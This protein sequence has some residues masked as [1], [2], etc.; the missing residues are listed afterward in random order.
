[1][2]K[3]TFWLLLAA[4]CV[5]TAIPGC[6]ADLPGTPTP[7]SDT[8]ADAESVSATTSRLALDTFPVGIA[9]DGSN[10]E[11]YVL[12]SNELVVLDP[13]AKTV[14]N[15]APVQPGATEIAFDPAHHAAWV[16]NNR[17]SNDPADRKVNI[18]D[19][20]SKQ[21]VGSVE[22]Q[23]PALA[24]GVDSGANYAFVVNRPDDQTVSPE[25]RAWLSVFDTNTMELVSTVELP[26]AAYAIE[27]DS[28]T[29][30]AVVSGWM[31]A[32]LV[33]TQT[34][35]IDRSRNI[36]SDSSSVTAAVDSRRGAAFIVSGEKLTSIDFRT[37]SNVTEREIRWEEGPMAIGPAGRLLVTDNHNGA[38]LVI[39]PATAEVRA[40]ISVGAAPDGVAST[41]D[42][43]TAYVYSNSRQSVTVVK[44]A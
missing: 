17:R 25:A 44:F 33:S 12:A 21:M 19:T 6:S 2:A 1:M 3:R 22:L 30:T 32:A 42:G 38:L 9:V 31:H 43:K 15:R 10:G 40:Q 41:P 29:H 37:G 27:I 11:V 20:R 13:D 28:V 7:A 18:F 35:A 39:D 16:A 8:T 34:F 36:R 23:Y 14:R 5:V 24:V 4:T 26:F